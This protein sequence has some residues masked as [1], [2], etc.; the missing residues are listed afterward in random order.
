M[1]NG[2]GE[3]IAA[4]REEAGYTQK[5]L[6][7][8]ICSVSEL[9]KMELNQ[10]VLGY[11]QVD[12]LFARLG[13]STE[14]LEYVLTKDI[15]ELYEVQYLIQASITQLEFEKAEKLLEQYEHKKKAKGALHKQ[16]LEQERAQIAWMRGEEP[17]KVLEVLNRAIER[18][19]K[20]EET[21]RGKGVLSAEELKLL[22]FRW[23]VSKGTKWE[24]PRKELSEVLKY[25]RTFD[26]E[27]KVKVYPYAVLLME[28][29]MDRKKEYDDIC[30]LLRNALELLRKERKILYLPE[31]LEKY[32]D[33]LD[34]DGKNTE[35]I[36]ELRNW[37]NS[38]LALEKEFGIYL[39]KYRLFQHLN[40]S[41]ELDYE[42]IRKERKACGISQEELS[43]GICTPESLSRVE[44][45][46]RSPSNRN[47]EY[48]LEKIHRKR[49]RINSAV[50]AERYEAIVL[51]KEITK[52]VEFSEFEKIDE[53]LKNL[54]NIL[55]TSAI[56]NKQ[57]LLT[58]RIR[59]A[60]QKGELS[61]EE[62]VVALY[63]SLKMTLPNKINIYN[64][65]LKHRES[66]ILNQ[67]ACQHSLHHK[68]EEAIEIW[69]KLITNYEE[70]LVLPVFRIRD[71]E[72]MM[73][74]LAGTMEELNI[75]D[76]TLEICNKSLKVEL[77]VGKGNGIGRSLAIMACVLERKRDKECIP[78]F[79]QTL[80]IMKLMK[81]DYRYKC[82][83]EYVEQKGLGQQ[84]K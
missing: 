31:I 9:T 11:F 66:N 62:G 20:Q 71:W 48:L 80:D 8:G 27:E 54:E 81:L 49:E 29:E 30:Y 70:S 79:R 2:I 68:K 26:E 4:L 61:Y 18:T 50:I 24:R 42:V 77:S 83:K 39:E 65:R 13:K 6:C 34:E 38:L 67:I 76:E 5:Q 44:S 7:E 60:L 19:I 58:E 45:G 72:L 14:R 56:E 78:R 12:R 46:K 21:L 37:R 40:R 84:I 43:E 82:I 64:C 35:E 59:I 3:I 22:L 1:R 10:S 51:E 75:L 16:F 52:S 36:K 73:G 69:K 17:E 74:N 23:E 41:F 53:L 57:Y 55:C 32:A 33:I 63:D 47:M 15:Y 28:S 25:L